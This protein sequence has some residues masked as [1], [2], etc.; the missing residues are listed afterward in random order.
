MKRIIISQTL[1]NLSKKTN[2]IKVLKRYSCL[3]L[4]PCFLFLYSCEKPVSDFEFKE[5]DP[6]I[7][8][9]CML[10]PDSIFKAHISKSVSIESSERKIPIISDAEVKVYQDGTFISEL[11]HDGEGFYTADMYPLP[12]KTYRIEVK[13]EGMKDVISET[14]IPRVNEILKIESKVLEDVP[15]MNCWGDCGLTNYYEFKIYPENFTE[16]NNYFALT[17]ESETY[18]IECFKQICEYLPDKGYDTC[19]CE[20][21]DTTSNGL[22]PVSMYF[23]DSKVKMTGYYE[24]IYLYTG[25]YN[26]EGWKLYFHAHDFEN[27]SAY[28][29][30]RIEAQNYYGIIMNDTIHFKL[31]TY[32]K[33]AYEFL[34]SQAK[35]EEV[36]Y[37][38]FA[39]KV[40]IFSN[41]TNGLGLVAGYSTQELKYKL[42]R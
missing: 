37:D 38:P 16:E 4:M 28:L 35:A 1:L 40:T 8:L 42:T 21:A 12:G 5:H 2:L 39:E 13:A 10:N 41:V 6:K 33:P 3:T 22:N 32:S 11:V 14:T 30:F 29:Q 19:Y 15:Y 31:E 36:E 27:T 23:N 18:Y 9:N 26:G 17:V 20:V 25:G 34:Y 24:D 7:V